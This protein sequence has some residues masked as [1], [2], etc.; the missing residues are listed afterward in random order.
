MFK[1]VLSFALIAGAAAFAPSPAFMSRTHAVTKSSLFMASD[2]EE[3]VKNIRSESNYMVP[4]DPIS[5]D[6]YMDTKA[7][8][9]HIPV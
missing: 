3:K 6:M 2:I 8:I 1:A 4:T 9:F 5:I 7:K